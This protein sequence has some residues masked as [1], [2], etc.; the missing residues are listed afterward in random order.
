M[1]IEKK[2]NIKEL[3][4]KIEYDLLFIM[5]SEHKFHINN[6][7]ISVESNYEKNTYEYSEGKLSI[8]RKESKQ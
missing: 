8:L 5:S 1:E 4:Q 6:I 7:F 2:F 3:T